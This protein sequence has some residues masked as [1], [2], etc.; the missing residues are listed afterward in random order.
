[1]ILVAIV[2]VAESTGVFMALG[3]ILDKDLSSKDLARGYLECGGDVN[4]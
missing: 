2:S 4:G 1:M 3:K